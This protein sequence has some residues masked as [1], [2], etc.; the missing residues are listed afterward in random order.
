MKLTSTETFEI[1]IFICFIFIDKFLKSLYGCVVYLLHCLFWGFK[2]DFDSGVC[3]LLNSNDAQDVRMYPLPYITRTRHRAVCQA[4]SKLSAR[5]VLFYFLF[6]FF[7]LILRCLINICIHIH[8]STF[9]Y[10]CRRL[11]RGL[12]SVTIRHFIKIESSVGVTL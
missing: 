8:G 10:S 1:S 6:S 2:Y 7:F 4:C 3:R 12:R 5:L 11:G 9:V